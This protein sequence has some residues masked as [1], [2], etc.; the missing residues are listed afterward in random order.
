[1]TDVT[2]PIVRQIEAAVK[3]I[4]PGNWIALTGVHETT[5]QF[6]LKW[7]RLMDFNEDSSIAGIDGPEWPQ[8]SMTNLR[9]ILLP[10]VIS[11]ATQLLPMENAQ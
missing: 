2:I 9:A 1:M 7:Y 5:G 8:N 4:R 11:V 3:D 10:G 6:M